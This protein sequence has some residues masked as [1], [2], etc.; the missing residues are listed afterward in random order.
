MSACLGGALGG[1]YISAMGLELPSFASSSIVSLPIY[2]QVSVIHSVLASLISIGAAFV[3][4]MVLVKPEKDKGAGSEEEMVFPV[5]GKLIPLSEMK[6]E[7]FAMGV[8]GNGFAVIPEEGR[9]AAPFDG[10]VT[11]LFPTNHAIGITSPSGKEILIHVGIDTVQ[12]NGEHFKAEVKQGDRVK[13]GQTLLTFDKD[14]IAEKYDT[15]TA[16]IF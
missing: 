13:K 3:L 8:L 7:T 2:F 12:L 10:T 9:V 4:T 11:A 6:D 5:S 15:T 14:A 16:V 1:A